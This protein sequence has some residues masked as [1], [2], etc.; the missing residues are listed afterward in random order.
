MLPNIHI[1]GIQ[2]SGK[3][4]QSTLLVEKFPLTYVASGILFRDRVKVGDEF[5]KDIEAQL[6]TGELLSTEDL[7]TVVGDY[8]DNQPK[9]T[10][11]LGDGVIRTLEQYD[12]LQPI[13]AK[14]NL[15]QPILIYLELSDEIARQRI[16]SRH[17]LGD[18]RSD[19]LP[20]AIKRRIE[21]FHEKTE[22]VIEQF[23]ADNSCYTI[24]ASQP[25]EQVQAAIVTAISHVFN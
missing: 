3:G 20:Q 18:V 21:L 17:N 25:V 9:L 13:W 4:T 22:P 2:G 6:A 11:L 7:L 24:D 12:A 23:K 8:L 14:H 15:T 1:L 5:A 10:G 16:A 19:D